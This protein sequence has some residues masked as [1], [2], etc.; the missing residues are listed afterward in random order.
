MAQ[1]FPCS[2]LA[3]EDS[4][5][6]F[7]HSLE[8]QVFYVAFAVVVVDAVVGFRCN[9]AGHSTVATENAVVVV[10]DDEQVTVVG[11][12]RLCQV[13]SPLVCLA[14]Q[15]QVL[16]RS[17]LGP[18]GRYLSLLAGSELLLLGWRPSSHLRTPRLPSW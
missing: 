6:R 5:R 1:S 14:N 10:A 15:E 2:V 4:R 9:I 7:S 3:T 11:V 12:V 18:E 8:L 17:M 16:H 13:A